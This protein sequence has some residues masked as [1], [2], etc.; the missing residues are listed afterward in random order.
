MILHMPRFYRGGAA[1]KGLFE[2]GSQVVA[3]LPWKQTS[4]SNMNLMRE[5]QDT[6][7]GPLPSQDQNWTFPVGENSTDLRSAVN[8]TDVRTSIE[9]FHQS[10][11]VSKP[12]SSFRTSLPIGPSM[13]GRNRTTCP[14]ALTRSRV[15]SL[16]DI[17]IW[18]ERRRTGLKSGALWGQGFCSAGD[19][20][21]SDPW[22]QSERFCGCWSR[23]KDPNTCPGIMR[24]S[25]Q[26]S[27]YI[28]DPDVCSDRKWF[29][30]CDDCQRPELKNWVRIIPDHKLI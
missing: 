12:R 24:S 16:E 15:W 30:I 17:W 10:V 20:L 11:D 19:T 23:D 21:W 8:M 26:T 5:Q 14:T 9:L 2:Q 6:W 25:S 27:V 4:E 13:W 18:I 22:W 7:N 28:Q 1:L 3:A 29:Y